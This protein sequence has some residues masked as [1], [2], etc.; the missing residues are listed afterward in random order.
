PDLRRRGLGRALLEACAA[1]VAARG[2]TLL[3]CNARL[4]AADF[5]R[6]CGFETVGEVFE[7]PR[8]G[9]HFIMR[10]PVRPA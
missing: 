1:H 5:Y 8:F 9:P 6:A 3:W 4:S 7:V 10:R 2:G